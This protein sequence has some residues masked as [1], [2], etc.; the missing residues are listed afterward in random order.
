MDSKKWPVYL[1]IK[2]CMGL[3]KEGI[4]IGS[5][6]IIDARV[7]EIKRRPRTDEVL[8]KDDVIRA[9]ERGEVVSKA[10][11]N[12]SLPFSLSYSASTLFP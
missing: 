5:V 8:T 6:P 4:P 9:F 12:G 7:K 1:E 10:G 2:A 11:R 3:R